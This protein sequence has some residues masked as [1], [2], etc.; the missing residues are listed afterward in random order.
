MSRLKSRLRS[1][2]FPVA[3]EIT[4]PREPGERVLLRRAGRLG[5]RPAAVNV[6]QRPERM[7]SVEASGVLHARGLEPVWHLVTRGRSLDAIRREVARARELGLRQVLC[8]RGDHDAPDRA[9]TPRVRE[10]VSL[11]QREIP[12]A[13]VG[14]TMN[15]YEPHERVLRSLLPK[16]HAGASFVQTQPVFDQAPYLSLVSLL[17]SAQSEVYVLPMLMPLLSREAALRLVSR[18]G[19]RVPPRQLER[20][21]LGGAGA[22]WTAFARTLAGLYD[23]SLADG[24]AVMTLELD[25]PEDFAAR[26]EGELCA[27]LGPPV[28]FE[29]SSN[30]AR[31]NAACAGLL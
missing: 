28:E 31:R 18:I 19:A 25:P 13:L 1:G 15:Q 10:V 4:P 17:K 6:I 29:N 7:S 24:V 27:V 2:G 23:S 11:V 21:E 26:L 30:T 16:L 3:L 12:E 8:I 5:A 22:G 14:V 20:L 9:D